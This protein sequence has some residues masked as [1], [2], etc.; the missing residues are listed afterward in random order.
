M[1]IDAVTRISDVQ[2][3]LRSLHLKARDSS[4]GRVALLVAAS[5]RNRRILAEYGDLLSADLPLTTG[6][7]LAALRQD[8]DPGANGIVVL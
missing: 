6:P 2:Q 3:L 4:E 5:R 8:R 1:R 7:I